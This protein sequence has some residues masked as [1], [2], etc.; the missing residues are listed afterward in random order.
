MGKTKIIV[1][2]HKDFSIFK[3]VCLLPIHV[4]RDQHPNCLVNLIGDNTGKNISCKNE[5]YS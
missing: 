1:C 2:Y 5:N 3:N 4:G